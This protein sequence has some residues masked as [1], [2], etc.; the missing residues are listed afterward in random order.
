MS[1]ALGV[2]FFCGEGISRGIRACA[3]VNK[4]AAVGEI[5]EVLLQSTVLVGN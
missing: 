1:P 3:V 2:L 5:L 4:Y